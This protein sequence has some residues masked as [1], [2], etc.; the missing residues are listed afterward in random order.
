MICLKAKPTT[1]Q[2]YTTRSNPQNYLQVQSFPSKRIEEDQLVGR[3]FG[4]NG[5]WGQ[6]GVV[7]LIM[8][9]AYYSS[10]V[11]F[12][13]ISDQDSPFQQWHRQRLVDEPKGSAA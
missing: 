6:S 9:A 11:T 2:R 1:T 5:P 8:S 12:S 10:L 3:G 7:A 4:R 13:G